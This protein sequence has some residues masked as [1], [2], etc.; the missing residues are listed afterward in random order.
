MWYIDD[1]FTITNGPRFVI[2]L[3]YFRSFIVISWDAIIYLFVVFFTRVQSNHIWVSTHQPT[4]IPSKTPLLHEPKD[5][6]RNLVY[7]SFQCKMPPINKLNFNILQTR[8]FTILESNR[9]RRDEDRV[10]L[11]PDR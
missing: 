2:L 7:M 5:P 8:L 10:I 6:S 9:P 4:K 1:I 11:A 3:L